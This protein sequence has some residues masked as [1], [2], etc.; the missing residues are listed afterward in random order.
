MDVTAKDIITISIS[1]ASLT[2]SGFALRIL[3]MT[4]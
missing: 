3:G 1:V 2:L 4:F